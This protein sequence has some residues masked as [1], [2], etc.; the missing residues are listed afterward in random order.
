M[1]PCCT[2]S[3]AMSQTT[4]VISHIWLCI[5]EKSYLNKWFLC[6]SCSAAHTTH[7]HAALSSY[8]MSS[9]QYRYL[10]LPWDMTRYL[11][12]FVYQVMKLTACVTGITAVLF[13][14]HLRNKRRQFIDFLWWLECCWYLIDNWCCVIIVA[15]CAV[16][17]NGRGVQK[18]ESQFCFF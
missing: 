18:V 2:S 5:L 11:N 17:T 9:M 4:F 6:G 12:R 1:A 8:W 15:L 13:T 3:C 10:I 16:D 7:I 14:C